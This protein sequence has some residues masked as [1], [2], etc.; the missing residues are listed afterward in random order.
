[1]QKYIN[2][3]Y[4]IFQ[5]LKLAEFIKQ[6][7]KPKRKPVTKVA[8]QQKRS[9]KIT[10]KGKQ[11][12]ITKYLK[13]VSAE[14]PPMINKRSNKPVNH[15]ENLRH[16]YYKEGLKSVNRYVLANVTIVKKELR[17]LRKV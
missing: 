6:L 5:V 14:L 15:F 3:L 17:K 1:M 9:L 8:R 12:S 4:S 7:A 13:Q 2:K 16:I 10:C 11:M